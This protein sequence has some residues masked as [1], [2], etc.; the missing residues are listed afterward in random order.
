MHVNILEGETRWKI[1]EEM[2]LTTTDEK[3]RWE[4]YQEYEYTEKILISNGKFFFHYVHIC[5][6]LYCTVRISFANSYFF[7][8]SLLVDQ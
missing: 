8:S 5:N 6:I 7:F 2:L 1:H 3:I 4:I